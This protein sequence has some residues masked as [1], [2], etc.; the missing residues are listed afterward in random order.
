MTYFAPTKNSLKKNLLLLIIEE[1]V[2]LL[3]LAILEV[4]IILFVIVIENIVIEYS[5]VSSLPK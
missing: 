5:M 1:I 4:R 3:H 2:P